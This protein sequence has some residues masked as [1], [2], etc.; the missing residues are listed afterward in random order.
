MGIRR[1]SYLIHTPYHK[2]PDGNLQAAWAGMEAVKLSGK[3]RSIGV[4]NYEE[5]HLATTLA[6]AKVAPSVNQLEFHPY[7][8]H[9]DLLPFSRDHGGGI[10]TAAYGALH[11]VTH[12][13]AGPL[14]QTLERLSVKYGVSIGLICLRWCIAQNVIVITTS[15]KPERMAEYLHVFD[16]KLTSEEV[17]EI[18]RTGI[19]CLKG[20][21]LLPRVIY[22]YRM[23]EEKSK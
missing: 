23:V 7:L 21:E 1:S 8:Q 19:D 17:Q 3:A 11:P 22:Y 6:T 13:I 20:E 14:D 10:A 18:S 16:F 9:G 15:Q 5:S 2:G 12:N 4:S